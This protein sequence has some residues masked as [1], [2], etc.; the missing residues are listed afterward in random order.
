MKRIII[1]IIFIS[2]LLCGCSEDKQDDTIN[3]INNSNQVQLDNTAIQ[4]NTDN[5]NTQYNDGQETVTT[6]STS[7]DDANYFPDIKDKHDI[8]V[9]GDYIYFLS[10]H[11]ST[12]EPYKGCYVEDKIKKNSKTNTFTTVSRKIIEAH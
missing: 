12:D 5:Q 8:K 1:L 6:Q 11:W 10:D 3:Q 4:S 7:I 9:I 2:V